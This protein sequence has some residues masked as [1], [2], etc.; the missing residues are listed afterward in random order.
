VGVAQYGK[1][2]VMRTF[3]GISY[4][5]CKFVRSSIVYARVGKHTEA[6]S[7]MKRSPRTSTSREAIVAALF[8]SYTLCSRFK[9]A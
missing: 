2:G 3:A 9:E 8:G 7:G 4:E 1:C 5:A 6:R